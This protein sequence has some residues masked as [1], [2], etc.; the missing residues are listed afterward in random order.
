MS[1]AVQSNLSHGFGKL[2]CFLKFICFPV[3]LLSFVATKLT[4]ETGAK[5]GCAFHIKLMVIWGSK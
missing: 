3:T 4:W 2:I 5:S 1:Q